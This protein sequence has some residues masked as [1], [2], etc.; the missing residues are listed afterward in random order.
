MSD[1]GSRHRRMLEAKCNPWRVLYLG[2][3]TSA[4][5]LAYPKSV[6]VF[7]WLAVA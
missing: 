7:W 4:A 3:A 5:E 6:L 2:Y 1:E